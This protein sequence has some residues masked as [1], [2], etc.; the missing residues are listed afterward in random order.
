VTDMKELNP[1]DIVILTFST[2]NSSFWRNDSGV[3]ITH[4]PTRIQ[5][6]CGTERSQHANKQIAM[7]QLLKLLEEHEKQ[8][9]VDETVDEVSEAWSANDEDYHHNCLEDLIDNCD[10]EIGDIVYVGDV[11]VPK[12]RKFFNVDRFLERINDNAFD[13]GGEHAKSFLDTVTP[14]ATKQLESFINNWL[15]ENCKVTFCDV[16]NIR[17]HKLTESDFKNID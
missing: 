6:I 14:E 7:D 3:K 12:P 4:I 13:E 8:T 11:S 1:K 16:K 9:S 5:S 15:D 17:R 2:A 10:L